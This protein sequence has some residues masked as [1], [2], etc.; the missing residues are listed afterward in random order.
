MTDDDRTREPHGRPAFDARDR[1]RESGDSAGRLRKARAL[2][3]AADAITSGRSSLQ[4]VLRK[5][6]GPRLE[7]VSYQLQVQG[8]PDPDWHVRRV[9]LVE[10]ISEPYELSVDLITNDI[11]LEVDEMLG[12]QAQLEITRNTFARRIPGIVEQVDFLGVASER[13]KVRLRIVPA[14]K[15]LTQR[16]DTRIFQDQT[17]PEILQEVLEPALGQYGRA[18]DRSGLAQTYL[19]RDYCVQY[20]ESDFAFAC[21]LM[22]EE[23]IAYI[24]EPEGGDDGE[25]GPEQLVLVDQGGDE[26]NADFPRIEGDTLE[27]IPIITD[28]PETADHESLRDLEWVRPEQ[29]TKVT[30]RRFNW[31]RPDPD[32]PP[33]AEHEQA[34][35]RDRHREIYRPDPRRRIEDYQQSDSY[36]GTTASEDEEPLTV[37]RF[38]MFTGRRA[39]GRGESNVTCMRA[40]GVFEVAEHPHAGVAFAGFLATRVVH[41]GDCADE[42]LGARPGDAR[43][44]NTLE[45]IPVTTRYRPPEAM[46]KPRVFG[47]QT[48]TVTGPEEEEIHTDVHGRI[49]VRFHWDRI[50][51]LD[52]SA[53]CWVRVAQMWAGPG[54]GTWF[55]PRIGMEV[56][57]EF[58][59]GNP[60]RPLVVGCV[61]NGLNGTP[62]PLPGEKTKS[63]IKSNSS[64]GGEGFNELRFEDAKGA[65]EIFI[66]AQRDQNE[67]VLN[68]RT[69]L[70]KGNEWLTIEGNKLVRIDG[71]PVHGD[72][73]GIVQGRETRIDGHEIL[74]TTHTVHIKAPE[75]IVLEVPGSSLVMEPGSITLTAG[76]GASVRLD[77]DILAVSK[78]RSTLE[79]SENIVED[80]EGSMVMDAGDVKMTGE[81]EVVVK[82]GVIRLN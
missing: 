57:V 1:A 16:V 50:S 29:I 22:Q 17:V 38:E 34:D 39:Y 61:Y 30:T 55:L 6:M 23:G 3:R 66:H 5:A 21:R 78:A 26:A 45:C 69:R 42:E 70:V 54:W 28:R 62:Y 19:V 67:R 31:K 65:E 52:D 7:Q 76:D 64:I 20:G 11:D 35:P 27:Q 46:P 32:A 77:E 43:Y 53:S 8:A 48:A 73:Q 44:H 37:K 47:P 51:P 41:E 56:V 36:R 68:N 82:G 33:V 2:E 80:T 25:E 12:A 75:R 15:L 24:F 79:L 49:K 59:D 13:L 60:D 9:H 72:P 74:E 63:T 71:A 10:A 81:T 40:G 14:F 58:L 4:G 18:L